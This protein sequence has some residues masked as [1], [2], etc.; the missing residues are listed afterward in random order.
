MNSL[1][2][3]VSGANIAITGYGRISKQ[4]SRLFCSLGAKVTIAARK[5]GDLALAETLG[6]N[7]VRISGENWSKPLA[8]GYDI[9][10]NTVPHKIFNRDFLLEVDKSTLLV[11]LASVPGGFD[12]PA[13]HEL[14]SN[15]CW[16]PSLPG[17][18][19]PESAGRL[20]ADSI[21]EI[22]SKEVDGI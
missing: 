1:K 10:F 6:Y 20:I 2:C 4:L 16:A 18:Y 3:T 15:I 7:T 8:H 19:A 14:G 12:I 17:K 22:I 9:I 5:D 13:V 21:I 11:E